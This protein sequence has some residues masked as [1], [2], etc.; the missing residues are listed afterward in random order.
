MF[1]PFLYFLKVLKMTVVFL[2]VCKWSKNAKVAAFMYK[3]I[4]TALKL[5]CVTSPVCIYVM[6]VYAS[7]QLNSFGDVDATILLY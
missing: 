2:T 5:M 7:I 3:Y 4:Y 6:S 1:P